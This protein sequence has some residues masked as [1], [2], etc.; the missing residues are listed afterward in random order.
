[1]CE[2]IAGGEG[3]GFVEASIVQDLVVD[4]VVVQ[5]VL[6]VNLAELLEVDQSCLLQQILRGSSTASSWPRIL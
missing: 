1:M 5:S 2:D 4:E 3:E 6:D